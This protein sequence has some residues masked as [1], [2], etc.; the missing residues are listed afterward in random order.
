MGG[1]YCQGA[2]FE[3]TT[4][5]TPFYENDFWKISLFY[6]FNSIFHLNVIFRG[7]FM[8]KQKI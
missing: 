5:T 4:L 6:G 1:I 8:Q 3:K 7:D 2:Y